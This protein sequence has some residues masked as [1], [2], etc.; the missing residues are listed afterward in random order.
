MRK[1]KTTTQTENPAAGGTST[2]RVTK[3]F[4]DGPLAGMTHTEATSVAFAVGQVIKPWAYGSGY[5]VEAVEATA[6]FL[7]AAG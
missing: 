4:T 2:Y 1:V 7:A 5:V 6:D 3:R